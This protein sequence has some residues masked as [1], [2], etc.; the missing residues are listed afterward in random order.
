MEADRRIVGHVIRPGG[1][2]LHCAAQRIGFDARVI[3]EAAEVPAQDAA[4]HWIMPPLAN[5]HDHARGVTPVSLGAFDLPLEMWLA[6]MTGAPVA[7]PWLV[8][9]NALGRQALS[10]CGA[11]MVHYTRPQDPARV[12]QELREVAR[13]ARTVGVRV[14]IAV[15]MRDTNA[16]GYAPDETVLASLAPEVAA[17]VRAR[18]LRT[19][20]TPAE[21]VRVV[22]D[23]AAELD[24]PLVDVQFG[25]YGLEWCSDALLRLV[26]ERSAQ[27][28][29]RVHM[30]L[31]ESP[32]QRE[33]L[34]AAFPQGPLVYLESI[35]LLSPRLSIGHGTQLRPAE[36]EKLAERGVAVSINTSSNLNIRNGLAPAAEMHRRG[37]RLVTGL[38]GFS[39]DDDDDLLREMR[40]NWMLHRGAGLQEGWPLPAIV[41]ASTVAGREALGGGRDSVPLAPGAA[42]DILV[43]RRDA[44]DLVIPAEE[45]ALLATRATRAHVRRL[46]VAGR[47][48]VRDGRLTGLD[49]DAARAELDAQVR[50]G[51]AEAR[52][53]REVARRYAEGLRAF[54]AAGLHRKGG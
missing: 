28:G 49:L 22:E 44:E 21:Q 53:W 39:L 31:L 5:G 7:D 35:G 13:A 42:A 8:V 16:L 43:L 54:Y 40:L 36:M 48:V 41:E 23:L 1:G 14:A 50:A 15:A 3:A 18:L 19:P 34:D 4:A 11:V 29:R 30:H 2:C 46:V 24:D 52:V 37:M 20:A 47:E 33:Y 25:P 17:A 10:G 26:A 45:P 38:D 12:P 32:I 51:A 6:V 9:A 27:T